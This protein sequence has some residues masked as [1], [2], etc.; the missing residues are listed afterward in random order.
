MSEK[1]VGVLAFIDDHDAGLESVC[2]LSD[3]V[4]EIRFSGLNAF[5]SAEPVGEETEAY[6]VR[7]HRA[8]LRMSGLTSIAGQ[9][10]WEPKMSVGSGDI[11]G[12]D[13]EPIRWH[14]LLAPRSIRRLELLFFTG[15]TLKLYAEEGHLTLEGEGEYL[16][17]WSGSLGGE[18]IS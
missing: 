5:W 2:L 7:I 16:E 18:P 6:E 10:G 11:Y 14:S 8:V 3:R 4:V 12:V 1:L 15:D 9:G 17:R 13:G